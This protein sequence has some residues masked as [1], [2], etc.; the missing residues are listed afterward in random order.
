MFLCVCVCLIISILLALFPCR[1]KLRDVDHLDNLVKTQMARVYG[2]L[3]HVRVARFSE[4][5]APHLFP[6]R[7]HLKSFREV[8]LHWC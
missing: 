6:W 2:F 3:K 1:D 5:F 7:E 4:R 8:L